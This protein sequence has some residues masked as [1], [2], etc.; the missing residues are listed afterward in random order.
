M[1]SETEK[2]RAPWEPKG[3]WA[4]YQAK[5]RRRHQKN[6]QCLFCVAKRKRGYATCAYHLQDAKDYRAELL[7]DGLCHDC[8]DPRAEGDARY[9][10][11]HRSYRKHMN[12]VY[13]MKQKAAKK[14]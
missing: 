5:R 4:A 12:H 10:A 2:P 7:R 11:Y 14:A 1:S 3:G 9:C 8:I 6:A 13:Y